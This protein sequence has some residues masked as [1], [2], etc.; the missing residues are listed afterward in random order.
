M[1]RAARQRDPWFYA[2]FEGAE[3]R[4]L[5][6]GASLTLAEKLEWLEE[7]HDFL[8]AV[9]VQAQTTGRGAIRPRRD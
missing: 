4:T 3:I 1:P 8:D 6:Q 2:T 9:A 5:L 7:T